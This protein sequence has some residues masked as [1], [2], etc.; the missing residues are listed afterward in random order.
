VSQIEIQIGKTCVRAFGSFLVSYKGNE[1]KISK[2]ITSLQEKQTE[3]GDIPVE[4]RNEEGDYY[5]L[6]IV[7]ST[8]TYKPGQDKH[9]IIFLDT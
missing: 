6:E 3:L 9:W 8:F 2:L 7:K 1:V 4:V 5:S